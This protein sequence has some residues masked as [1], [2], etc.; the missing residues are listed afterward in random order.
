MIKNIIFTQKIP[1]TLVCVLCFFV[2]TIFITIELICKFQYLLK[3]LT[4]F[5]N[6]NP[7]F[8]C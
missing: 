5:I 3:F 1:R 7:R 2:W 6:L 4:R 8:V